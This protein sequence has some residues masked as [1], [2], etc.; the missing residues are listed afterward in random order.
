MYR[1]LFLLA[2]GLALAAGATAT[3]WLIIDDQRYGLFRPDDPQTVALGAS[4]Y[5]EQCASCHGAGL[6]GEDDWKQPKANGRMPAPPHD[7]TG[8]TWHHSDQQLFDIT[9]FGIA[10]LMDLKDYKTDMPV[11]DGKLTDAEI[12][13][14]LSYIKAQWPS[15]IRK[16][17]DEMNKQRS[18]SSK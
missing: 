5:A 1:R 10:R 6:E 11:Y 13:A 16:R 4:V 18:E 8:H 17:H 14:A 3:P 9:K 2:A 15:E 12:I 7:E